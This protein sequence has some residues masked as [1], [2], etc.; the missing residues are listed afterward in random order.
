[1]YAYCRTCPVGPRP[2]HRCSAGLYRRRLRDG[3]RELA[4]RSETESQR[5]LT[6][7]QQLS[8]RATSV[9]KLLGAEAERRE[10]DQQSRN[11]LPL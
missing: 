5:S 4:E 10:T 3:G 2:G 1:M 6:Q 8:V 11:E 7:R 9:F